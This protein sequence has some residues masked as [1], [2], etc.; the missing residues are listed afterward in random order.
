MDTNPVRRKIS[1]ESPIWGLHISWLV[2]GILAFVAYVYNYQNLPSV[3]NVLNMV[4]NQNGYIQ[5]GNTNSLF[6]FGSNN[7]GRENE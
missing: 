3:E 7:R 4:N 5:G 1:P 2:A 6:S